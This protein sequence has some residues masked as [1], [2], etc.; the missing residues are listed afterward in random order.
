[1]ESSSASHPNF[2]DIGNRVLSRSRWRIPMESSSSSHPNLY[3]IGNRVLSRSRWRIPMESSS[4]SYPNFNDF[5]SRLRQPAA[6]DLLQSIKSFTVSFSLQNPHAS[7]DNGKRV[8][9]FLATMETS[10]NEHPLWAHA[11]YEEIDNA[12]ECLEKYIMTK[13]F[14][15]TFPSSTEDL[16][17][18]LEISEKVS[19]LQHFI[20][21]DHLDVPRVLQNEA[22]W[23]FAAKE[24]QKINAFK[25][26]RDKLLC[27]INCCHAIN[28]LLLDI[29]MTS[30]HKPAGDDD[31]LPILIYVTIKA[32]PPQLHSNLKYVKL[33]RKHSK[34]VSEVEYCLTNLISAKTFIKSIDATSLSMDA[35]Q[36]H[37]RM[38]LAKLAN[39]AQSYEGNK[40]TNQQEYMDVRGY[41]RY[42]F[43]D[44]EARDLRFEDVHKLLGLYKHQVARYAMLSEALNQLSINENQLLSVI[45]VPQGAEKMKQQINRNAL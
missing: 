14:N 9:D 5:T 34:L 12:I 21:P 4:A 19:L 33:F 3:D 29:S 26:P 25:A 23:L 30:N 1:M 11:S 20:K 15:N 27:I 43:M 28:N 22:S 42:P 17:L 37:K 45:N 24:L 10:I 6:A 13:L 36:F 44:A 8:Q 38:Q 41:S 7:Y 32:N 40:P 18:D 31:F 16:K 2:Y 35:S 39:A